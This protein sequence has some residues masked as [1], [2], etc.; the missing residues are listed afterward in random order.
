MSNRLFFLAAT[1]FLIGGCASVPDETTAARN[2]IRCEKFTPTGS[3]MTQT[4]CKTVEQM[5]REREAAQ[6][7]VKQRTQ[8]TTTGGSN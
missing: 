3:H 5:D 6:T 1:V 8:Q 2:E 7:F 4:R